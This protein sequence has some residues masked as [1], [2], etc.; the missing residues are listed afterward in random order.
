MLCFIII[1]TLTFGKNTHMLVNWK[2][3]FTHCFFTGNTEFTSLKSR[4]LSVF[5]CF[6]FLGIISAT[7]LLNKKVT[8]IANDPVSLKLKYTQLLLKQFESENIKLQSEIFILNH[9]I[10]QTLENRQRILL[11]KLSKFTGSY[12]INGQGIIIRVSDNKSPLENEENPNRGIIHDF[13]LIKIMNDLWSMNAKAI[14]INGHRITSATQ[15]K[16]IGPTILINKTRATSPFEIKAIGQINKLSEGM[17]IGYLRSLK[18]DGINSF[19]E[20]YNNLK[21]PADKTIIMTGGV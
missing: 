6:L 13:D 15:I 18:I 2:L 3:T 8:S 11:K 9:Q 20:K 1:F 12:S 4:N 5:L 19:I 16:C 10:T 7:G 14:S 21:I 17:E